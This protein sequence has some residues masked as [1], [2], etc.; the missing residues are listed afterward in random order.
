MATKTQTPQVLSTGR[1][2]L[3]EVIEAQQRA[4]VLA[5]GAQ[6]V[7]DAANAAL[8]E[9]RDEAAKYDEAQEDVVRARLA[10]LKGQPAKSPDEIREHRRARLVAH[11]EVTACEQV[12]AAAK[13][14]MEEFR[15]NV[16]RSAKV[17]AS[18]CT[19][20][21]SEAAT[22]AIALWDKINEQ[23]QALRTI[24]RAFV[25]AE[26][27]LDALPAQQ[28]VNIIQDAV[29]SAGLPYGD[30]QDWKHLQNRVGAALSKNYAQPD[31][32][33]SI[34]RARKYWAVF[35]SSLSADASAEQPALPS[36]AEL[37]S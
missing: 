21:L 1:R 37:F 7:V 33:D 29:L 3:K 34:T 9:A 12:L 23:H 35:A 11:E 18:H 20:V 6:A 24:L 26:I 14:E 15:G 2:S 8:A 31:P 19:S 4:K 22:D 27:H 5:D 25:L 28:Q 13:Q 32:T 10:A 30:A 17:C 16:A 36:A